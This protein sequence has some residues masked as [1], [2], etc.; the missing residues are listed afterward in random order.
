M[1]FNFQLQTSNFYQITKQKYEQLLHNTITK[2]YKKANSNTTKTI[3]EQG[4]IIANKKDILGRIQV[5]CKRE[6]F[7]TLKDQK[8]NLENNETTR[9][10]YPVKNEMGKISK[11]ILQNVNKELRNKLQLQE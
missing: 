1:T 10:I 9:L 2:T 3:D 6:C 5:N 7:I 11:V 8:P 4:K